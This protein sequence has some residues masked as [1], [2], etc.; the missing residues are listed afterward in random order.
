MKSENYFLCPACN[1]GVYLPLK[2]GNLVMGE[3]LLE[4]NSLC[5]CF[6]TSDLVYIGFEEADSLKLLDV[7]SLKML[8][9]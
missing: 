3:Y 1:V 8:I 5:V 9:R 7:D 2:A 4:S 6:L